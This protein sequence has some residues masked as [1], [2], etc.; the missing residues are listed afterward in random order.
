MEYDYKLKI[1]LC[2]ETGVGKSTFFRLFK[3]DE[4]IFQ[5]I[6]PTIGVDFLT[7]NYK[8]DNK[9][10]KLHMWDTAGEE[11]YRTIITSYF[12]DIS[13]CII[14]FD[15]TNLNSFE[16]IPYWIDIANHYSSSNK[17]KQ[18]FL[19]GNK[20]DLNIFN[21]KMVD[22]DLID[23]LLKEYNITYYNEISSIDYS[24]DRNTFLDILVHEIMSNLDENSSCLNPRKNIINFNSN[25]NAP[26]KIQKC[27]TI[28]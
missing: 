21:K 9:I 19:F 1:I 25:E 15:L 5:S 4:N 10:V 23:N 27:C 7:K 16:K 3:H 12:K 8:Y 6:T 28:M 18:I 2:G 14:I 22:K 26:E 13:A 24:F 20:N 11:R 17:K